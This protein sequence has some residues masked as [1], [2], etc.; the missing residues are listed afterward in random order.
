MATLTIRDLDDSL[1]RKLRVRAASR[2]RSM[3]AEVRHIL[4]AALA[5]SS[6]PAV[7]I[8]SRIRGRFSGL[9]DIELVIPERD[10][11]RAPP[12]FSFGAK[13]ARAGSTVQTAGG[14]RTGRRK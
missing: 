4:R 7:D 14:S 13:P 12:D 6:A 8:A 5:E 1:K 10:P 11:V 3:E 2:N 9:G